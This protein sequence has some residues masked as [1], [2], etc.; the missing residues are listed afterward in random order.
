MRLGVSTDFNSDSP[1]KWIENLKKA[2]CSC[3]VFPVDSNEDEKVIDSYAEAARQNNILIAEVGIWRNALSQDAEERRRN[4]EYSIGQLRMAD[5]IGARCCVNVAGSFGKR[6]DGGYKE[7]YSAEAWKQTVDMVRTIID[8]VRPQNTYFSLEPMP[9]MIPDS[10]EMYLKLLEE[11]DREH[12]A[13]HMDIINMINTPQRYFFHDE[14]LMK[15]FS[16]LGSRIRSCHLKDIRLLDEYT[17]R[18]EECAC[19]KGTFNLKKYVELASAISP[20]MPMIIE[21]LHSDEEYFESA[22]WFRTNILQG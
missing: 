6:W 13:V 8:E 15:T 5:R 4:L 16:I 10:P 22:A 17:F 7:N 2:G 3:A 12:F 18:L 20:D 9:W 21:H 14:F 1:E 11:V 19:G